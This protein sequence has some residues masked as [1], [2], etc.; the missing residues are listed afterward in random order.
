[1]KI[2]KAVKILEQYRAGIALYD[3]DTILT[4]Q[5]R[6]GAMY[7]A[8]TR[9]L[10]DHFKTIEVEPKEGGRKMKIT[11][12]EMTREEAMRL[13]ASVYGT[14]YWQHVENGVL[15]AY[16]LGVYNPVVIEPNIDK[17]GG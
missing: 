6:A 10:M 9:I 14:M 12:P 13:V 11:F 15:M 17:E 1:M 7:E 2:T 5:V 8:I 4:N 16:P 3:R